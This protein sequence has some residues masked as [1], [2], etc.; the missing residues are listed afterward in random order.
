MVRD[1]SSRLSDA[2]GHPRRSRSMARAAR[3]ELGHGFAALGVRNY[4][5][6]WSGQVVSLV[7]IWM[8]MVSLPWLVLALGGSPFQLGLVAAFQFLPAGLLAPFGGVFADRV[9]KRKALIG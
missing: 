2:P 9:D 7:G 8:Q 5:L 6:Y 1:L 4:R 3:S